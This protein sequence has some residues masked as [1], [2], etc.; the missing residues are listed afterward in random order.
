MFQEEFTNF[1]DS[2]QSE[3]DFYVEPLTPWSQTPVLLPWGS[4]QISYAE[5]FGYVEAGLGP[6]FRFGRGLTGAVCYFPLP[7]QEKAPKNDYGLSRHRFS[8]D[9]VDYAATNPSPTS[10][11]TPSVAGY[12]G[13]AWT[14]RVRIDVDAPTLEQAL[15]YAQMILDLLA[16]LGIPHVAISIAFSGSKGFHLEISAGWFGWFDPSTDLHQREKRLVRSLLAGLGD[17]YDAKV[18]DKTR[19]WRVLN[20]LNSKSGLHKIPLT[21][22]EVLNFDVE[23]IRA[24]AQS[25][26]YLDLPHVLPT[27]IPSLVNL[28][29]ATAIPEPARASQT[30]RR[31][32][33]ENG[34]QQN[35]STFD[36]GHRIDLDAVLRGVAE[37]NRNDA[38]F[39]YASRL[40]AQKCSRSEAE[41]LILTAAVSCTPPYRDDEAL[42]I[43]ANVWARYLPGHSTDDP[44][45]AR[46]ARKGVITLG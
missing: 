34:Q 44:D 18:Y 13:P 45:R 42:S 24:L 9:L 12:A 40:R 6:Q 28:W 25:P 26:R 32:T 14:D 38:L 1:D 43:V 11:K 27:P 19:I 4:E 5:N 39:R 17:V 33:A 8:S 37:G 2:E 41:A 15:R 30:K 21:P 29:N 22:D 16:R 7:W 31:K 20:S 46:A 10:G 3:S 35:R 23:Q 36:R